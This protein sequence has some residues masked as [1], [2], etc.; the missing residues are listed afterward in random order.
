[1]HNKTLLAIATLVLHYELQ[2]FIK[3]L[4]NSNDSRTLVIM[5]TK[6][7]K[8]L[9][10][11]IAII[12][13][14]QRLKLMLVNMDT[15]RGIYRME[16]DRPFSRDVILLIM[17]GSRHQSLVK[18]WL[19][20]Y[21]TLYAETRMVWWLPN[22]FFPQMSQ[23]LFGMH[24][25]K[26][27][28]NLVFIHFETRLQQLLIFQLEM[29]QT[30]GVSINPRDVQFN[31]MGALYDRLF[32]KS[33]NNFHQRELNILSDTDVPSCVYAK[34]E[35]T[36]NTNMVVGSDVSVAVLIGR[37]LNASIR[38]TSEFNAHFKIEI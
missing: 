1:M 7:T 22:E 18:K 8:N 32:V 31:L 27:W 10:D 11:S 17:M 12:A 33:V 30:Q 16:R 6:E 34:F 5:H 15:Q 21:S 28:Y 19:A 35:K 13:A 9:T 4:F 3:V 14:E 26:T 37:Y 29:F 23:S 36:R 20:N 38:F 2:N 25:A 24:F